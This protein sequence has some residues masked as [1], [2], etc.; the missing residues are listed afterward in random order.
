[1]IATDAQSIKVTFRPFVNSAQPPMEQF[2]YTFDRLAEVI[3]KFTESLGLNKYSIYLMDYGA[4]VWA[5]AWRR[6]TRTAY[7]P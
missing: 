7:R 2:E 3:E 1:M 5:S 4:P 6:S